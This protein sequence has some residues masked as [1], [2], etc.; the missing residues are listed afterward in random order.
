VRVRLRN[1]MMTSR[2]L[3]P[4]L[5]SVRPGRGVGCSAGG[6]RRRRRPRC[7]FGLLGLLAGEC[8]ASSSRRVGSLA[9][10]SSS[11]GLAW[12][13]ARG[14]ADRVGVFRTVR[15]R[16]AAARA[17]VGA[18]GRLPSSSARSIRRY[19]HAPAAP[20]ASRSAI[21]S[22]PNPSSSSRYTSP[23]RDEST[24]RYPPEL[25]PYVIAGRH[26][27]WLQVPLRENVASVATASSSTRQVWALAVITRRGLADGRIPGIPETRGPRHGHHRHGHRTI[28]RYFMAWTG[29]DGCCYR[30]RVR[31]RVS[32]RDLN[33]CGCELRFCLR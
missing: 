24:S 25:R 4:T 27:P 26:R 6:R 3:Q 33:P 29:W 32:G 20:P 18:V 11:C 22:A 30:P 14:S 23:T 2:S 10:R 5:S 13:Y 16:R 7:G 12:W 19:Y 17:M 15:Y 8:C 9:R 1:R 21:A 28:S 31:R